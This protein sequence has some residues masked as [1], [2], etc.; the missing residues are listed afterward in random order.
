MKNHN[1][2]A[3][4]FRHGRVKMR[5]GHLFGNDN[6][7]CGCCPDGNLFCACHLYL[8][9]FYGDAIVTLQKVKSK[10]SLDKAFLPPQAE[11]FIVLCQIIV[12][13]SVTRGGLSAMSS[14]MIECAHC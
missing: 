12:G 13:T 14:R 2:C 3:V 10:R 1:G 9:E 8:N 7:L 5:D 4:D 6:F 11:I